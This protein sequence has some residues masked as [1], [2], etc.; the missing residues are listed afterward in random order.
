MS[1]EQRP[2]R[3]KRT[4]PEW[5]AFAVASAL[6][7]VVAG[8]VARLWASDDGRPA[9]V[10][11]TVIG[12]TRAEGQSHYVPVRITNRGDRTAESVQ[13][14][15]ELSEGGEVVEDG[16]QSIDFL[17]GG[18]EMELEFVFTTDPDS[19]ELTV[20]AASYTKP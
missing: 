7:L 20:R 19:A 8:A 13:V 15:A 16:E 10:T 14:I 12:P 2:S 17:A 5:F 6:L 3:P 9:L 18:A 4:S 1:A 11:A